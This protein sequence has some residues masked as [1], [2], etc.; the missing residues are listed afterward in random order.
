MTNAKRGSGSHRWVHLC[1][2]A[3]LGFAL[4]GCGGGGTG[5]SGSASTST[6]QAA[7]SG[8]SADGSLPSGSSGAAVT[9]NWTPPT[10]NTD[11]TPLT[12]LSE[13]GRAHV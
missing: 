10:E 7:T 12:N 4:S 8:G 9:L 5:A 11:G 2:A 1:A 3:V 13:I 6:A